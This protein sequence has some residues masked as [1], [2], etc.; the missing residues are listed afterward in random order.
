[1]AN[2]VNHDS[3]NIQIDSFLHIVLANHGG[4]IK[5]GEH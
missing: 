4:K 1:M 5:T 2:G 3:I